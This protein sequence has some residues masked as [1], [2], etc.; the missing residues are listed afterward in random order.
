MAE[1]KRDAAA[2]LA[3]W[4]KRAKISDAEAARRL[5]CSRSMLSRVLGRTRRPGV[6]LAVAIEYSTGIIVAEWTKVDVAAA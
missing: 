4:I 1:P 2:R 5:G 6:D 3:A